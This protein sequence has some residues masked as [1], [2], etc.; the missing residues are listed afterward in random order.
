MTGPPGHGL[1]TSTSYRTRHSAAYS[2]KQ[3]T[4]YSYVY[5]THPEPQIKCDYVPKENCT[6]VEAKVSRAIVPQVV[7][8]FKCALAKWS[9]EKERI[10]EGECLLPVFACELI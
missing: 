7:K 9:L 8:I 5:E 3:P 10:W 1:A 6:K 2:S 4:S